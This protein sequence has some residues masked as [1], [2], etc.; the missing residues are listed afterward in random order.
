MSN[1][2]KQTDNEMKVHQYKCAYCH[3]RFEFSENDIIDRRYYP[4][5]GVTVG[6]IKCPNCNKTLSFI[7]I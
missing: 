5:D 4:Q 7:E 3:Y 6:N 1:E 2:T